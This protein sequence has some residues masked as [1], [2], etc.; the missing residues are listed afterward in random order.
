MIDMNPKIEIPLMLILFYIS[1]PIHEIGHMLAFAAYGI[2]TTLYVAMDGINLAIYT[3]PIGFLGIPPIELLYAGGIFA[4][5]VLIPIGVYKPVLSYPILYNLTWAAMEPAY[6][7]HWIGIDQMTVVLIVV[8]VPIYL[9]I[10]IL[11][12]Q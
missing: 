10:L 4:A 5:L 8:T 7:F 6:F 11:T 9:A 3:C 12:D 2:Q 1:I